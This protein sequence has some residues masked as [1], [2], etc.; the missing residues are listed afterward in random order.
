MDAVSGVYS[1]HPATQL[2]KHIRIMVEQHQPE[3]LVQWYADEHV[4]DCDAAEFWRVVKRAIS[5]HPG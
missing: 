5:E 1:T 4:I 3:P 2:L